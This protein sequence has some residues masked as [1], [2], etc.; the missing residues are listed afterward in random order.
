[1]KKSKAPYIIL[2]FVALVLVAALANLVI[3]IK[4]N[5]SLPMSIGIAVGAVFIFIMCLRTA[6]KD[7]KRMKSGTD[8]DNEDDE[9]DDD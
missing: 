7:I 2:A 5:D 8:D 3:S 6:L 4:N 1:M 9:E